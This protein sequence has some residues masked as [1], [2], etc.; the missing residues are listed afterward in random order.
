MGNHAPV[1][2]HPG[3]SPRE[4]H[5]EIDLPSERGASRLVMDDLLEQL[6]LHGW[7]PSD[8]FGIHLA[9][10][11]AI[12]NAIVHGN[13][14]DPAKTVHVR[15][16]VSPALALIEVTDAGAGFDPASIPD[17][18]LEERLEVPSGRGVMLMRSFMTRIEYN[19]RGNSVLL[20]KRREP[21]PG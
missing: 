9:V 7:D 16:S 12:V 18:T 3:G 2:D 13:K 1:G 8:I 6:G 21:N 10:E 4:W 20:E 5:R 11:E 14:L 19:A 15:C 17:C